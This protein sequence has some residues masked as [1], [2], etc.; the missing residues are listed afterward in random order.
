[1]LF[2]SFLHAGKGL[3]FLLFPPHENRSKNK[4]KNIPLIFPQNLLFTFFVDNLV[5]EISYANNDFSEK[6]LP[7]ITFST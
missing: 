5:V 6:Y 7:K 2:F 1:V 4:K 3:F